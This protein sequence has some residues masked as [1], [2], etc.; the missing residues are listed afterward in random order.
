LFPIADGGFIGR[1]H[2][3]ENPNMS[4]ST[5]QKMAFSVDEAAMRA[6]LGRDVIYQALRDKRL[7]GKKA[8]R[9]TLVTAEALKQFLDDLPPYATAR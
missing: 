8:G 1:W 4:E 2:P 6:G 3:M 9:R 7:A 5:I